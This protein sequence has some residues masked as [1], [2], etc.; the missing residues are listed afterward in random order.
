M[1]SRRVATSPSIVRRLCHALSVA[2][3]ALLLTNSVASSA[4]AQD[5]PEEVALEYY[6]AIASG[7]WDEVVSFLH[8]DA[9]ADLKKATMV[10]VTALPD[11][12]QA[13]PGLRFSRNTKTTVLEKMGVTSTAELELLPAEEVV[14]RLFS[15][16]GLREGAVTSF[17]TRMEQDT[18]TEIIGA[19]ME[20]PQVAHVVR[21]VRLT[22][23]SL[24]QNQPAGWTNGVRRD[25]LTLKLENGQWKVWLDSL[26]LDISV[27]SMLMMSYD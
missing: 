21:R 12:V 24:L 1:T 8:A 17:L 23:P 20:G 11:S 7:Q 27:Q 5:S 26:I 10:A 14:S 13:M 2:T 9:E 18:S 3:F 6:Q 16:Q 25:V 4:Y 15:M 19:V 22:D